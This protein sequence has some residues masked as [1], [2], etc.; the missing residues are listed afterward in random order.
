VRI[1]ELD[2]ELP[3][4]LIAQEPTSERDGARL[5]C[6]DR[7]SGA[8]QHRHIVDLAGLM[9]PSLLVLN[10]TRVF[11]AR[12]RGT[13]SSG[14]QVELLLIEHLEG[15]GGEQVWRAMGR[16]S[17]PLRPGTELSFCH[18]RLRAQIEERLDQGHMRVRLRSDED[19]MRTVE[20][21]G[22]LPLPPYIRRDVVAA[23]QD[24]Y[25]TL[26]ARETGSIAAP[27]AGLHLSQRV[28]D[29]LKDAGHGVAHVTLHVGPGTFAPLRSDDLSAHPMHRERFHIPVETVDAIAAAKREGRPVV[30]VGT[31]VVRTLESAARHGD[32]KPGWGDTALFIYPPYTFA[33]VE[34]LLTNFHLPRSTLLA[35][36]M[37]FSGTA[38]ARAA[39]QV[40]VQERY[41][42][43]SYG[44][45]MLISG[46]PCS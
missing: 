20:Q 26:F 36:V 19:V 22:E 37:A 17:K 11:P 9:P 28:L 7:S 14:G 45:A 15:A 41:R 27:T 3:E 12:L 1:D 6:L 30:A 31:T 42:F 44:D 16:A 34:A 40:A 46:K 5:L 29:A 2:Y 8:I 23:D 32:M 4:A 21:I 35:L 39:Y 10:D 43:F 33:V 25:Q 13:R 38:H 18:N 24:R